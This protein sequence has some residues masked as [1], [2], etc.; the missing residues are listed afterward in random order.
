[1]IQS[2]Q[3][4]VYPERPDF[5]VGDPVFDFINELTGQPCIAG[6]VIEVDGSNIRIHHEDGTESLRPHIRLQ[7]RE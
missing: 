1:M 7:R 3:L 4:F 5:G 6:K 2:I